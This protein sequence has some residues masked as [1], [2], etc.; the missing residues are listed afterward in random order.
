[1]EEVTSSETVKEDLYTSVTGETVLHVP[2]QNKQE[3][4][5]III[6]HVWQ[7]VCVCVCVCVC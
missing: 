5:R 7:C 6:H 1:M 2:Q 3:E 4:V